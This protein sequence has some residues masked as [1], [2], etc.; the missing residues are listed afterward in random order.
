MSSS[1]ESCLNTMTRLA[2]IL[3]VRSGSF[4]WIWGGFPDCDGRA[5]STIGG[6]LDL[7]P[8]VI[9]LEFTKDRLV[10]NEDPPIS[11]QS[12]LTIATLSAT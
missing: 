7:L 6:L 8:V 10:N 1:E 11:F 4:T 12:F 2:V 5:L 3:I 9:C